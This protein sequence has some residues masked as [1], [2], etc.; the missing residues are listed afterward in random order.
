MF[1]FIFR[2]FNP[3]CNIFAICVNLVHFF[4][5][6][7]KNK[8]ERIFFF[9]AITNG[10]YASVVFKCF[11]LT[12]IILNSNINPNKPYCVKLFFFR[13]GRSETFGTELQ[14]VPVREE[15]SPTGSQSLANQNRHQESGSSPC[16]WSNISQVGQSCR[17]GWIT[18][19]CTPER[20]L[21]LLLWSLLSR[22][23]T[24][25]KVDP[26]TANVWLA[27]VTFTWSNDT[28]WTASSFTGAVSCKKL[29]K[30]NTTR[31]KNHLIKYHLHG[32]R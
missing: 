23:W 5:I 15:K 20:L 4:K 26:S 16:S 2:L 1:H 19:L 8:I 3:R 27:R 28:L 10:F 25:A 9:K 31:K 30:L 17:S 7:L 12:K 22:S 6:C 14:G 13:F 11:D 32:H 24:P 29:W 21:Q 18:S